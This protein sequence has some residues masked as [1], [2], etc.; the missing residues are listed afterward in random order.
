MP[1]PDMFNKRMRARI[2]NDDDAMDR[3]IDAVL[4]GATADVILRETCDGT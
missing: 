2:K 4:A 1:Q 3:A